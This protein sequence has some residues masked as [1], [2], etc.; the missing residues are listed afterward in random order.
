MPLPV[1]AHLP[2]RPIQPIEVGGQNAS[3]AS[4]QT[5]LQSA[6]RNVENSSAA[7]ENQVRDFLSGNSQDLHTAA[8]ATQSAQLNLEEFLQVRNKVVS[9]Y[10][11][12]MKMQV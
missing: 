3:A 8:L 12:I 2:I 1:S 9:A 5:I 4:F 11:E 7:A 10:E 6:I